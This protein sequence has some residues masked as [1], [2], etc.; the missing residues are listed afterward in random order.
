MPVNIP[1]LDPFITICHTTFH[2]GRPRPYAASLRVF[3]TSFNVS[4]ETLATIGIIIIDKTKA[5]AMIENEPSVN[6]SA[7]YPVIPI[8]IEGIPVNTSLKSL[9]KYAKCLLELEYS[10]RY[11]PARTPTGAPIKEANPTTI[12]V[13]WMA[14]PIPPSPEPEC[15]R[16]TE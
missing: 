2:F 8:T 1:L 4:S 12:K 9:R 13:P 10:D 11:T 16:R 6:T 5:P 15:T 3:G 14:G 7:I